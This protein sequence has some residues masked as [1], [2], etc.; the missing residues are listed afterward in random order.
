[1][2]NFREPC[3]RNLQD[4]MLIL[5]FEDWDIFI[6]VGVGVFFQAVGASNGLIWMAVAGV[7]GFLYFFKRGKPARFWEHFF[8]WF[9]GAKEFTAYG[10]NANQPIKGREIDLTLNPLQSILPYSHIED[11]HLVFLDESISLCFELSSPVIENYAEQDLIAYSQKIET[12]L[13]NSEEKLT[14]QAFFTLDSDYAKE[15]QQHNKVTNIHPL[16]HQMH[17]GRVDWLQGLMDRKDFRRMRCIFFVNYSGHRLHQKLNPF[18]SFKKIYKIRK[19]EV[20]RKKKE[21]KALVHGLESSFE[22]IGFSLKKLNKHEIMQVIYK[23]LNPDRVK[24]GIEC[25]LPKEEQ[26]FV[27]QV[28]CSDFSVDRE[29]GEYINYGGYYHKYISLKVLPEETFPAM[30]ERV[31]NLAFNEF[32][33]VVNFESPNKEWGRKKI[34]ALRKREHGN[35]SGP[36]GVSNR[37]AQNK[38]QQYDESIDDIQQRNQ[39]LFKMQLVVHVYAETIDELKRKAAD[40]IQIFYSLS[41]A[42]THEERWG[43]VLPI[44]L[45]SLPGWTRESSR[46]LLMKTTHLA[47]LLPFFSEFK[48]SGNAECIFLNST[49]GVAAFDPFSDGLEAYNMVVIGATGSGKSFTVNQIVNQYSKNDPIEIFIDVGGSYRRQVLL[50]EGEYINLNLKEKFTINLFDLGNGRKLADFSE[51]ERVEILNK[52]A[53]TIEQMIGGVKRFGADD[54][55][56]SDYIFRSIEQMYNIIDKPVLGDLTKMLNYLSQKHPPFSKFF[57]SVAGLLGIW[58][59]GGKY[60]SF[61]DGHSTI[62]L[63]KD[64]ICFDL[65]GLDSFPEF[66]SVMFVIVTNFVWTK[67]MEDKNRRKFVVFDECWKLLNTPE[68]SE[69]IEECYRTFRKYGA[70][71]ISITQSLHDFL[72]GKLEHAVLGNTQTRFILRQNSEAAVREIINYFDFNSQEELLIKSLK[73]SKGEYSEIFFSQTRQLQKISGVFLV[74]PT[75]LEYWVATTDTQDVR[76]FNEERKVNK[77]LKLWEVLLLCAKKHPKGISFEKAGGNNA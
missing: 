65:K 11:G 62:S 60:G 25:P 67:I 75:A 71:A 43:A 2:R 68:A 38:I 29:K 54:Q 6:V 31:A 5:G 26:R 19:E 20:Q 51:E 63:E 50:K 48:G 23:Y 53:K 1:M 59:K 70:G 41:G 64:V 7:G 4:K 12:I 56:V 16:V 21:L 28:C 27:K 40:V 61:T 49:G 42:E 44:F 66:Q 22:T 76:V 15:I 72:G 33:I 77:D 46:Y 3:L 10:Q 8:K 24:T 52:K 9:S 45:G 13:S 36:F 18:A 32:D 34:I 73:I 14:Y 35:L 57:D 58:L 74:A 37:E 30:L 47:D 69:F 39:K 55:I 17:K